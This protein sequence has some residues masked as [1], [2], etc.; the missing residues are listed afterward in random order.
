MNAVKNGTCALAA[1]AFELLGAKLTQKAL[2][3]LGDKVHYLFA[4]FLNLLSEL[5]AHKF[6][7]VVSGLESS[8][9]C[10]TTLLDNVG[11][12]ARATSVPS[13]DL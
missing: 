11:V 3:L 7:V 2:E 6:N 1:I 12:V 4:D 9:D 10:V 8:L 13:K 5:V